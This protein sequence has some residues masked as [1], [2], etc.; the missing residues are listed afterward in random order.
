MDKTFEWR[1]TMRKR[2][3]IIMCGLLCLGSSMLLGCG[4]SASA[5]ESDAGRAADAYEYKVIMFG[6]NSADGIKLD[7]GTDNMQMMVD[8]ETGQGFEYVGV[9]HNENSMSK[10]FTYVLFRKPK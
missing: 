1:Q 9:L 6:L 4:E 3:T 10:S 2:V 7:I 8:V 5:G